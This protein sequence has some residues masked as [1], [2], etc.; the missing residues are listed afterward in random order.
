MLLQILSLFL[1]TGSASAYPEMSR[2]GYTNC[3][4][5]HLS[6]SGWGVLTEYGRA[7]SK[8]VL[9]TWSSEVEE[10]FAYG[11]VSPPE[12]MLVSAYL[13]GVQVYK[14]SPTVKE[15][16]PI[17]MQADGEVAYNGTKWA[18][19]GTIGRQEIGP[20]PRAEGRVYSRRHFVMVRPTEEQSVRLGKFQKFYGLNDPNHIMYVRN[21]LNFGYDTET[22]NAEYAYLGEHISAYATAFDGNMSDRYNSAQE[23]GGTVSASYFLADMHK[24]GASYYY[25][26]QNSSGINQRRSVYG[27][28]F[29]IAWTKSLYSLSELDF[30]KKLN[31]TTAVTQSG[32]VTSNRLSYEIFK[33][34]LPFVLFDRAQLNSDD[35]TSTRQTYGTGMQWY[36]RP[37]FEISAAW[38]K[39]RVWTSLAYNDL[40]WLMLNFYL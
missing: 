24:L 6:P 5:C 4:A 38:Q 11:V 34:V 10:K 39:E 36:P 31:R 1:F 16:Y 23:N 19:D 18:V 27:P 28:W 17:L 8:E 26:D 12:A 33:G 21:L 30:Q 25:G 13:R 14:N 22:Y 20:P 9:S 7:L 40:A 15:G 2:H 35:P 37:H 3:T 32:Y 29:I